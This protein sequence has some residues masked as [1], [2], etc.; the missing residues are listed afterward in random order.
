MPFDIV[1][2]R[3]CFVNV[4]GIKGFKGWVPDQVCVDDKHYMK[5]SKRDRGLGRCAGH[6]RG[7]VTTKKGRHDMNVAFIDMMEKM[8]TD[9]CDAV[10]RDALKPDDDREK[11]SFKEKRRKAKHGDVQIAP[12]S[13]N[14]MLPAFRISDDELLSA[15]T[16][17]VLFGVKNNPVY[18]EMTAEN[19]KY[20]TARIHYDMMHG[21]RG[22]HAKTSNESDADDDD[23]DGADGDV[24]MDSSPCKS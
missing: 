17:E 10:V 12:S 2:E 8:R 14:I 13:V 24:H 11:Q 20:I 3:K 22:R 9:A 16:M 18:V 23:D 15:V 1:P 19:I 5:I 21:I 4:V 6:G 7:L